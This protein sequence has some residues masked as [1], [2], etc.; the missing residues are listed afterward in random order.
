[1]LA[2]DTEALLSNRL[3]DEPPEQPMLYRG[4]QELFDN[5][6]LHDLPAMSMPI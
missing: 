5:V 4:N 6:V 3:L 1:M 2:L